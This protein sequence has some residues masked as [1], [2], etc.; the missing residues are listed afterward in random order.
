MASMLVAATL[1]AC[2]GVELPINSPTFERRPPLPGRPDYLQTIGFIDSG[3]HYISPAAKFFV[4]GSGDMCFWDAAIVP[5]FTPVY[6][7]PNYWCISPFNV[8]R[9]EAIENGVTYIDRVRLWCRLGAPQCA[10]K[11]GYPNIPDYRWI[12]NSITTETVPFQRQREAIAYLVY[13][14]GGNLEHPQALQ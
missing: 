5:G 13:L 14:M 3:V 12:A 11:V 9:V 2:I 10:Y 8:S 1:S 7:P 4:S 6:I